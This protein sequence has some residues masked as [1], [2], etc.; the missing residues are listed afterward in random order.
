MQDKYAL[1]SGDIIPQAQ[2][3]TDREMFMPFSQ[4]PMVCAGKNVALAEMRAVVC[5]VVRAFDFD[6]V[7]KSCFERW[8]ADVREIFVTKRGALPVLLKARTAGPSC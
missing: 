7:D 4:G 5:A 1:P 3:R 2:V 6:V 8:E